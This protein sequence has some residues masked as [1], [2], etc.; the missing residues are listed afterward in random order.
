VVEDVDISEEIYRRLI[1][2]DNPNVIQSESKLLS[3][4]PPSNSNCDG[5]ME[6]LLDFQYLTFDHHK[7]LVVGLSFLLPLFS[8]RKYLETMVIGLGGGIFPMFLYSHFPKV[9]SLHFIIIRY[10]INFYIR[11]LFLLFSYYY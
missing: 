9:R 2:T 8:S 1:F 10:Q 5:K 11:F 3:P 4:P 6:T 7:A